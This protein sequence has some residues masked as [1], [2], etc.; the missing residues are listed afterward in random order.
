MQ[1]AGHPDQQTNDLLPLIPHIAAIV[2]LA[3]GH[4]NNKQ[5]Q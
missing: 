2:T 4:N 3:S 5:Q 1:Y